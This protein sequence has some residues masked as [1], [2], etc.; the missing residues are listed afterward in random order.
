MQLVERLAEG[1]GVAEV[2]AGHGD[3]V[4]RLP[5]QPLQHAEHDRLLP[6]QPEGVDAVDQVDAQLLAD[7]LN[8][9]HGIVEVAGDLHRQRAVIEGLRE[10]A[11]RDLARADEDDRLHQP[12][13]RA[14]EGQR[15]AGVAGRGAGGTLGAH[16]PG[17]TERGRHAVVLEAARGI[18]P[19]VLQVQAA[20]R[21]ADVLGHAVG[22]AQQRLP[23]ADSDALCQRR[24]GSRSWNRHTPLKQCGSLRRAHFCSNAAKRTGHRSRSHS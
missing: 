11:V 5:A 9:G 12:G 1:A 8:A 2:S 15:G 3:P 4:G 7:F 17:V 20:G 13:D 22:S 16:Q 19:F 21:K 23:F 6:F 24:K 18:H 14:V 10:L